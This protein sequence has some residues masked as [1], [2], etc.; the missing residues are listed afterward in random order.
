MNRA[1]KVLLPGFVVHVYMLYD[2]VVE[3]L[4]H[5]TSNLMIASH[6]GSKPVRPF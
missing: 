5:Q 4:T 1:L 6:I 3:W 2:N